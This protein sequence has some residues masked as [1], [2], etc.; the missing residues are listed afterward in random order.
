MAINSADLDLI[1]GR[2]LSLNYS[3]ERARQLAKTLYDVAESID[4]K[5]QE[6]LKYVSAAGVRFDNDIYDKLNNYRTNSSQIGF[7]DQDEIPP[8][9]AGQLVTDYQSQPIPDAP[10]AEL[11][12][13]DDGYI[14]P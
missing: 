10:Y 4:V 11:V 12:Y 1:Y 7:L 8:L 14:L 13:V 9:L 3:T 2:L 6:I 5:P